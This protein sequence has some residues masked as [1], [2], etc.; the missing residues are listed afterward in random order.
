MGKW[1]YQNAPNTIWQQIEG[2]FLLKLWINGM[3]YFLRA[4]SSLFFLFL[5]LTY[6]ILCRCIPSY[7]TVPFIRN[8]PALTR[9]NKLIFYVTTTTNPEIHAHFFP[10]TKIEKS[11]KSSSMHQMTRLVTL[12][13]AKFFTSSD[14]LQ[15]E[16]LCTFV[17][18]F[19]AVFRGRIQSV[20][21]IFFIRACY[22]FFFLYRYL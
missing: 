9:L 16:Q 8:H 19:K 17:S 20:F 13:E 1:F 12:T 2:K 4:R 5:C 14:S 11:L 22:R 10:E 6:S 3:C 21:I 7:S 15:K 18:S